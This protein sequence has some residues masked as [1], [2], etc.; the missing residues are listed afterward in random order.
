MNSKKTENFFINICTIIFMA[1]FSVF[2]IVN[3]LCSLFQTAYMELYLD[4]E[5]PLYKA[6]S[7][8]LLIILTIVFLGICILLFKKKEL[9]HEMC[10]SLEK[11]TLI[12]TAIICF[13]I[14]FI[15]RVRIACDSAAVS[16]IAI[17]FLEGDFSAFSGDG[18]LVHYPHQ[19]GWISFLMIGYYIFGKDNYIVFQCIN[20]MA[21]LCT[22]YYFHR[23]SDI[24]FHDLKIKMFTSVLS[25]GMLPLFLFSTFIY[26]DVPGLG[27]A[28]I[29]VYYVL[30]Y[31][32]NGKKRYIF[33]AILSM[34]LSIM[35]KSN[36]LIVLIAV[37]MVLLL[38]FIRTKDKYT[39]LFVIGI[40]L[41]VKIM[42]VGIDSC[43]MHMAGINEMPDGIPKIAWI[44]MGLQSNEY[45][46]NGWYNS[47]N[48]NVYNQND[49]DTAKTT[50]VCIADIKASLQSFVEAPISGIRFFFKKF[51]SQWNDPTFNSQIVVE[52]YSRHR[53]DQSVLAQYLIYGNGRMILEGIMNWYHFV[54]LLGAGIFAV[55]HVRKRNLSMM[56][57]PL[58]VVGGYVFHLLWEAKGRYGLGYFVLCIPMAAWGFSKLSE[59]KWRLK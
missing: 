25:I 20:V 49:L 58:C 7:P 39:L 40:V 19:L 51:I 17:Q 30:C 14:I 35:L 8:L 42:N 9:T 6:D 24:L 41:G 34:A 3:A 57:L 21:I 13:I 26:G 15:F 38:N 44:A 36:N 54:V 37:C 46:E 31:L 56:L 32:D 59:I 47:Y 18:Y 52:W 23:I 10:V 45:L 48:W 50:A 33:P 12:W 1:F 2:V 53:D 11:I 16:E 5:K 43:F 27:L 4:T 22:V 29:S 55:F 28:V